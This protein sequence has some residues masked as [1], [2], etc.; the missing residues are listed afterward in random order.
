MLS[1]KVRNK[2]GSYAVVLLRM[3]CCPGC[4][5]ANGQLSWFPA[6]GGIFW[7]ITRLLERLVTCVWLTVMVS[8]H[9]LANLLFSAA[10]GRLV[11]V[12]VLVYCFQLL[13]CG[14]HISQPKAN[15][16]VDRCTVHHRY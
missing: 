16:L 6:N 7:T 10:T 9:A 12:L 8:C 3:N 13:A 11:S 5:A 4:A 14:H 15:T 1:R 2:S